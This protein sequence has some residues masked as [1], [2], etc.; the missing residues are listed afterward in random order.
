MSKFNVGDRVCRKFTQL[1]QY[2]DDREYGSIVG[3]NA[4]NG[5]FFVQ[6]EWSWRS[7]NPFEVAEDGLLT[8]EEADTLYNKLEAEFKKVADQ[9]SAHI[10]VAAEAL[11]KANAVADAANYN[12][13]ELDASAPLMRAMRNC[14]WNTSSLSC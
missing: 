3:T 12:L 13:T 11:E 2:E 9:V 5:K 4:Q 10:K 14:G 1:N 7:P 8:E 6:S